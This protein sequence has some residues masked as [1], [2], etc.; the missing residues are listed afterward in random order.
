MVDLKINFYRY[1]LGFYVISNVLT[2]K[3]TKKNINF[4]FHL[5]QKSFSCV[6][7]HSLKGPSRPGEVKCMIVS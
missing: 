3:I 2:G 5:G 6:C 1:G 4:F 7:S